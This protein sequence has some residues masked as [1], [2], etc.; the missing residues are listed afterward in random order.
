MSPLPRGQAYTD[1]Q[2]VVGKRIA[3]V[4][5]STGL[6]AAKFGK[7]IGVSGSMVTRIELGDRP[8]SIFTL[9][10]ISRKFGVPTDFL[11]FGDSESL[12]RA[13]VDMQRELIARLPSVVLG[14][15]DRDRPRT[16]KGRGPD[17]PDPPKGRSRAS[18]KT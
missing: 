3:A 17:K 12:S 4:R 9:R 11:L 10:T 18:A 1:I 2:R 7:L 14:Q 16:G 15:E 5:D 6:S 13:N 8:P